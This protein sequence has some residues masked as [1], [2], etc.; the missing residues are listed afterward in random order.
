MKSTIKA[1]LAATLILG[2][3]WAQANCGEGKVTELIVGT[4]NRDNILF[5]LDNSVTAGTH[6]GKPW[7]VYGLIEPGT[8]SAARYDQLL[9]LLQTALV[10]GKNVVADSIQSNCSNVSSIALK[11]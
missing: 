1:L 7:G 5:K 4:W 6:G 10:S 2:A 9:G 11:K 8:M 3:T